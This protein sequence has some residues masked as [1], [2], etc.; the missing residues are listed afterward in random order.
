MNRFRVY[1]SPFV[2]RRELPI[3]QCISLVFYCLAMMFFADVSLAQGDLTFESDR[4]VYEPSGGYIAPAGDPV[5]VRMSNLTEHGG[6]LGFEVPESEGRVDD[7]EI[8]VLYP[9][10]PDRTLWPIERFFARGI[11]YL[12][13]GGATT[14]ET[15]RPFWVVNDTAPGL[16]P[17]AIRMPAHQL[18][19]GEPFEIKFELPDDLLQQLMFL[20]GA[21]RQDV[22]DVLSLEAVALGAFDGRHATALQAGGGTFRL[23]DSSEGG[24]FASAQLAYPGR[25][26]FRLVVDGQPFILA[27][28]EASVEPSLKSQNYLHDEESAIELY[29]G[30][31]RSVRFPE[32]RALP[33]GGT[34]P[35]EVLW[36]RVDPVAVDA[37]FESVYQMAQIVTPDQV[38]DTCVHDDGDFLRNS[39]LIDLTHA[40][41]GV[42]AG[43]IVAD[44]LTFGKAWLV[45][46]G[47]GDRSHSAARPIANVYPLNVELPDWSGAIDVRF[48]GFEKYGND[49]WGISNYDVVVS[50]ITEGEFAERP[51]LRLEARRVRLPGGLLLDSQPLGTLVETDWDKESGSLTGNLSLRSRTVIQGNDITLSLPT[52]AG[53]GGISV[54]MGRVRVPVQDGLAP[55]DWMGWVEEVPSEVAPGLLFPDWPNSELI[56]CGQEPT[57]TT[58]PVLS[59][60][61]EFDFEPFAGELVPISLQVA[62]RSDHETSPVDVRVEIAGEARGLG[63]TM[64]TEITGSFAYAG[65]PEHEP[66]CEISAFENPHQER[67]S[68]WAY[69]CSIPALGAGEARELFFLATMPL[70]GGIHWTAKA[71][72]LGDPF[73]TLEGVIEQAEV[74]SDPPTLIAEVTSA[75]AQLGFNSLGLHSTIYPVAED[76]GFDG[77]RQLLVIGK[78]LPLSRSETKITSF[79]EDVTYSF[80]ASTQ[81]YTVD[82][83]RYDTPLQ[84]GLQRFFEAKLPVMELLAALEEADLEAIIVQ[85]NFTA[86]VSPGI[87]RL[88]ING[89]AAE[90]SLEFA[91]TVVT[92]SFARLHLGDKS[93]GE[94]VVVDTLFEVYGN[95]LVQGLIEVSTPGLPITALPVLLSVLGPD[96]SV[97]TES[98][99]EAS[100][101]EIDGQPYFST[102]PIEVIAGPPTLAMDGDKIIAIVPP[103]ADAVLSLRVEPS[104]SAARLPAA[105]MPQ[106]VARFVASPL[107]SGRTRWE[108]AMQQAA[109]CHD[110]VKYDPAVENNAESFQSVGSIDNW[111]I[112]SGLV[113]SLREGNLPIMDPAGFSLALRTAQ[114]ARISQDLR[115]GHHA[116]MI[117]LRDS[118]ARLAAE[119]EK[120]YQG[121]LE[122]R[123]WRVRL[124]EEWRK[125][126]EDPYAGRPTGALLAVKVKNPEW[127]ESDAKLGEVVRSLALSLN[128]AEWTNDQ[129]RAKA[130]LAQVDASM[131]EALRKLIAASKSVRTKM[132]TEKYCDLDDLAETVWGFEPVKAWAAPT[133]VRRFPADRHW[134]PDMRARLWMDSVLDISRDARTQEEISDLESQILL[135]AGAVVTLPIGSA[136]GLSVGAASLAASAVE[137]GV[138][139]IVG[140]KDYYDSEQELARALGLSVAIG[141]R[142]L[143]YAEARA[144][145][146]KGIMLDVALSAT[147]TA[148]DAFG[149]VRTLRVARGAKLADKVSDLG[150]FAQLSRYQQRD[151]ISYID[152]FSATNPDQVANLTRTQRKWLTEVDTDELRKISKETRTSGESAGGVEPRSAEAPS[153]GSTESTRTTGVATQADAPTTSASAKPARTAEN[154][155]ETNGTSVFSGTPAPRSSSL[156]PQS[157][158]MD[159]DLFG[160]IGNPVRDAKAAYW[161]PTDT[162]MKLER[163]PKM[164]DAIRA[165]GRSEEGVPRLLPFLGDNSPAARAIADTP[166]GQDI[167]DTLDN[168]LNRIMNTYG[169]STLEH[170]MARQLL[171]VLRDSKISFRFTKNLNSF[172]QAATKNSVGRYFVD[173][174]EENFR[175][176]FYWRGQRMHI[177]GGFGHEGTHI[178]QFRA[179]NAGV[180]LH[181]GTMEYDATLKQMFMQRTVDKMNAAPMLATPP[182]AIAYSLDYALETEWKSFAGLGHTPMFNSPD[183]FYQGLEQLNYREVLARAQLF[184]PE[185]SEAEVLDIF[186]NLNRK[187]YD[188]YLTIA[189][190]NPFAPTDRLI[191]TY[192]KVMGPAVARRAKLPK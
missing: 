159:R 37:D 14:A 178:V 185:V 11:S 100:K 171:A 12:S 62:N 177:V 186:I 140:A 43:E 18:V 41:D 101:I 70:H 144:V 94:P 176:Q 42:F 107:R 38:P 111:L 181:P 5:T 190:A 53:Y 121:I 147:G 24:I 150:G 132:E 60:F 153:T 97:L 130:V 84:T 86:G 52:N 142:R 19:A 118:Y 109:T 57:P 187:N 126:L 71:S 172:G 66:L 4:G 32:G 69:E 103:G 22:R 64:P 145:T 15:V 163:S 23:E 165:A 104:F 87:K 160:P 113:Q 89:A 33:R 122:S 56:V 35:I 30:Y 139:L 31:R 34:L 45:V 88:E 28:T 157:Q 120:R 73:S 51:E 81:T 146:L 61:E 65:S 151:L 166:S 72:R 82:E 167:L 123:K 125:V 192:N 58:L 119:Q 135:G 183:K 128:N 95:D 50:G 67:Q 115:L 170:L 137:T 158:A 169:P 77:Q 59:E 99:F 96:G 75:Y 21:Q 8:S 1:A 17:S 127:P 26:E 134:K 29:P 13:E 143:E 161:V 148:G 168:S 91:D 36:E 25:Y 76:S 189:L 105:K 44:R 152:G 63:G 98:V 7:A 188:R 102:M 156:Y 10:S 173:F 191:E 141:E 47:V 106:G 39:D 20:P 78:N 182:E 138:T 92:P 55:G 124:L 154:A 40:G 2:P 133:L 131:V 179:R 175:R 114:E 136:L 112:I 117:L 90:W 180:V 3:W 27:K 54:E 48:A 93:K 129:A 108:F 85:A 110:G 80:E 162:P 16:D 149:H 9:A 116:A 164:E 6:S 184:F 74:E 68:S 46:F 83:L 155:N 49:P 174:S 79:D